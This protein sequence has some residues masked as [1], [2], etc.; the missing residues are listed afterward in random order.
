M[1]ALHDPPT[2]RAP[3]ALHRIGSLSVTSSLVLL[4]THSFPPPSTL[5]TGSGTQQFHL[6]HT[7]S[8]LRSPFPPGAAFIGG[9]PLPAHLTVDS[10]LP[11]GASYTHPA[12]ASIRANPVKQVTCVRA[13][14]PFHPARCLFLSHSLAHSLV[15]HLLACPP[16]S[17]A[18]RV[19]AGGHSSRFT[20]ASRCHNV[21]SEQTRTR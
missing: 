4:P 21:L 1:A 14:L 6:L 8:L 13:L 10:S 19:T 17:S 2:P 16:P 12:R 11:S 7:P 9:A 20:S 18:R 3:L 5:S 15:S